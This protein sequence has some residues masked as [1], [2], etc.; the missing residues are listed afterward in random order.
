MSEVSTI[1][2]LLAAGHDDAAAVIALNCT[3]LTY[4]GLR[5][6]VEQTVVALNPRYRTE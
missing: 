3:A 6:H 5:A 2:V 1:S 4:K